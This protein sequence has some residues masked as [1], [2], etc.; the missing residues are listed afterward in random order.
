MAS[1]AG[2]DMA[3]LVAAARAAGWK[4]RLTRNS[5]LIFTTPSGV[6][7]TLAPHSTHRRAIANARAHLKRAGLDV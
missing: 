2:K 5:H 1:G 3:A 4:E 6:R 7:I